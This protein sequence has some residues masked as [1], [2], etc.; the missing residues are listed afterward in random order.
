MNA[1]PES[2]EGADSKNYLI[3]LDRINSVVRTMQIGFV[4]E[5]STDQITAEVAA[6]LPENNSL[7]TF[8]KNSSFNI[9]ANGQEVKQDVLLDLLGSD[10]R[11]IGTAIPSRQEMEQM[12]S[13]ALIEVG[14]LDDQSV[15]ESVTTLF[16]NIHVTSFAGHLRALLDATKEFQAMLKNGFLPVAPTSL[17]SAY[18]QHAEESFMISKMTTA[19]KQLVT[20]GNYGVFELRKISEADKTLTEL[21]Y[22]FSNVS[23]FTDELIQLFSPEEQII[24]LTFPIDLTSIENQ[25]NQFTGKRLVFLITIDLQQYQAGESFIIELTSVYRL[26]KNIELRSLS[27]SNTSRVSLFVVQ[28]QMP[29]TF[30]ESITEIL[31]NLH[32]GGHFSVVAIPEIQ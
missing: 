1:T 10:A 8:L 25:I 18:M 27:N 31:Y 7:I 2:L 29:K 17:T 23:E 22:A 19:A 6:L 11:F 5:D 13:D 28:D 15:R 14:Y 21:K 30:D 16:N 4:V 9:V 12:L 24:K 20:E 26:L 3:I 32:L